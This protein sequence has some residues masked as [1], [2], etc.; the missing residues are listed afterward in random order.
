MITC[1]DIFSNFLSAI[2]K[3][4]V[5]PLREKYVIKFKVELSPSLPRNC[6]LRF[7]GEYLEKLK[8]LFMWEVKARI[9]RSKSSQEYML[10][11]ISVQILTKLRGKRIEELSKLQAITLSNEQKEF[12]II[13]HPRKDHW[14]HEICIDFPRQY[15]LD[16]IIF[17]QNYNKYLKIKIRVEFPHEPYCQKLHKLTL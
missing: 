12:F 4:R 16:S 17:M 15:E 8:E 1:S 14:G 3:L 7:E 9:D 13:F 11:E 2:L 5:N 10:G 6:E